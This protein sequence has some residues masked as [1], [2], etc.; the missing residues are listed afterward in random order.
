[1]EGL[2][3]HVEW[4]Q[5]RVTESVFQASGHMCSREVGKSGH[6]SMSRSPRDPDRDQQLQLLTYSEFEPVWGC[7]I[8]DT[9]RF[10]LNV[11][12]RFYFL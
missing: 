3:R 10:R 4:A 1:M 8:G 7:G 9:E 11:E 12:L 6:K 2:I 5:N